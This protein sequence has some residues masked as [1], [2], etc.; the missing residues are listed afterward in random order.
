MLLVMGPDNGVSSAELAKFRQDVAAAEAKRDRALQ[1]VR[2]YASAP[3]PDKAT[4]ALLKAT[5]ISELEA[6]LERCAGATAAAQPRQAP[7]Q[8]P[9]PKLAAAPASPAAPPSVKTGWTVDNRSVPNAA[10]R[11]VEVSQIDPSGRFALVYGCSPKTKVRYARVYTSDAFDDTASY[12]PR[13]PLRLLIDGKPVAEFSFRFQKMPHHP[14]VRGT[15]GRPLETVDVTTRADTKGLDRFLT[16]IRDARSSIAVSYF[17][18]TMRFAADPGNA[19]FGKVDA[20]CR[21]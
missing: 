10:D 11:V 15:Q 3:T 4:I 19:G 20:Q 14:R 18:K 16:A 17:D 8:K 13:V 7:I 12:A 6:Q 5:R 1:V 9:A 2:R 21:P